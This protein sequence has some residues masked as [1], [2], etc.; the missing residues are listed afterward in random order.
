MRKNILLVN[1]FIGHGTG[2]TNVLHPLLTAFGHSVSVLLTAVMSHTYSYGSYE[3]RDLTEW[4]EASLIRWREQNFTFDIVITGFID[5]L[6]G[7]RQFEL[8]REYLPYWQERGAFLLVDPVMGDGGALYPTLPERL[9]DEMRTLVPHADLITPNLTEAALLLGHAMPEKTD[10]V[11]E[12]L[13]ELAA[14][15]PAQVVVTDVSM[16]GATRGEI[17]YREANGTTGKVDFTRLAADFGG[18]G[19]YFNAVLMASLLAGHSLP[20]AVADAAKFIEEALAAAL[21]DGRDLRQGLA[22]EY[23]LGKHISQL[24]Q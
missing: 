19:D 14:L 23:L 15:G 22:A 9:V 20:V 4:F 2:T 8:L 18:S 12:W 5:S 16:P 10:C 1:D 17:W 7:F 13:D 24:L 3:Y 21:R 6:G 11:E